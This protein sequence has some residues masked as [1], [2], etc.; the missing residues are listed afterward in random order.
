MLK[1]VRSVF[2]NGL[3][4]VLEND[5]ELYDMDWNGEIYCNGF[6]DDR[7]TD[8]RYK[9]IYKEN[10]KDDFELLGFEEI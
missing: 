5:V 1:I 6:K 9:P 4:Y 3:D 8:L 7:D 2:E 10:A